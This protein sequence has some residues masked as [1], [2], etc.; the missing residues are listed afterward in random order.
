VAFVDQAQYMN[1]LIRVTTTVI[2]LSFGSLG[3]AV[4]FP[5][6][7]GDL[8]S[9]SLPGGSSDKEP[10]ALALAK[11]SAQPIFLEKQLLLS[12]D[13]SSNTAEGLIHLANQSDQEIAISLSAADFKSQTTDRQLNSKVVFAS[14]LEA[15]GRQI[16]EAKIPAKTTATLKLEAS[17]LWEAGA[18]EAELFNYGEQIGSLRAIKARPAFAVK[19]V[20]PTPDK[21]DLKFIKGK[22]LRLMLKNDDAM[23]YPLVATIDIDGVTSDPG[24]VTVAPNGDAS[25]DLKTRAEWFPGDAWIKGESRDGYVRLR[26]QPPGADTEPGLPERIIP[27]NAHLSLLDETAES[28]WAYLFVFLLLVAGGVCSLILSN[29][30]PNSISRAD[31]QEQ[32]GELARR[33]RDISS[34]VD[35]GLRVLLRVERHRQNQMLHSRMII[36]A[37]FAN[38]LKQC[39]DKIGVLSNQIALATQL[40]RTYLNLEHAVQ[41]NPIPTKIESVGRELAKA[42]DFLRRSDPTSE[43]LEE[44]KKLITSAAER[45]DNMDQ[46]DSEFATGLLARIAVVNAN[47]STAQPGLTLLKDILTQPFTD[48]ST[49]SGITSIRPDQYSK[50]D[51]AT[52]ELELIGEYLRYHDPINKRFPR[53]QDFLKHLNTQTVAGLSATKRLLQEIREGVFCEEIREALNQRGADVSIEP[54]PIEDRLVRFS[55]QF[56]A[57]RLNAAVAR[58]EMRCDWDFG[59][60]GLTETGWDAYHYFPRGEQCEYT[61]KAT[62]FQDGDSL[63]DSHGK[64]VVLTKSIKVEKSPSSGFGDRNSGEAVRLGIALIIAIIGLLAGARD[65]LARLDLFA[66]GIAV[67]LLGFGA[68]TIKNLISP[69]H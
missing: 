6:L 36:G 25:V 38:V 57:D 2:F 28:F 18:A 50:V 17:N 63:V 59:H 16:Y 42:A 31:T 47:L 51:I 32:L 20:S 22:S 27:F 39:N 53:Q 66:A 44:A 55:V 8:R 26:F 46:E 4:N 43:D 62:F 69:K 56:R 49:C 3:T 33:T 35:S 34:R 19:L 54:S 10:K 41:Y 67:F 12:V 14:P 1:H 15:T 48:F 7:T 24:L 21:P 23:T 11:E 40:D 5:I 65:Q 37:E 60:L 61:V 45:I 13:P 30:V 64:A 52:M 9:E 68:D 58:D 29:W